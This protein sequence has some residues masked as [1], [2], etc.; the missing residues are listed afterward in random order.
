M[1]NV[2]TA[3]KPIL[4]RAL[5]TVSREMIGFIPAVSRDS[6]AESAAVGQVVTYHKVPAIALETITPGAEPADSGDAT[7]TAGTMTI[8][9]QKVAPIR[10]EG[11][12]ELT[13]INGDDP[14]LDTVVEDQF[15]QAFRAVTN[16]VE[17][18]LGGLYVGA[19][20]AYGTAGTTP[21][22]TIDELDDASE[23]LRILEDNGA[24]M[25]DNHLVLG[26]AATAKLRGYQGVMFKR[27]EGQERG[28][29]SLGELFGMDI[30]QSGQVKTHTIGTENGAYLLNDAS[31]AIGDTSIALDTGAGTI[32]AGDFLLNQETGA[33]P[34]YYGVTT[35]LSGGAAVIAEPG[36]Q[37]A[38]TDDDSVENTSANFVANMAFNRRAIQ[39]VA[40]APQMPQ[41]GDKASDVFSVTDPVSGLTFQVARYAQYRRVKYE[42]GLAWGAEL[43]KP[44]HCAVLFG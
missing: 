31:S 9:N 14:Q 2:I 18:D 33:D 32:V 41:G 30:H 43:V 17:A 5:D 19:S 40:R 10:W 38:W 16:A 22:A 15:A 21:F 27:N 4:Y 8:D 42:I 37:V 44:E 23:V 7:I 12:E 29:D 20:R 28:S 26:S 36:L 35:A 1:S 24:P 34:R 25:G 13:L 6:R 39:L 11:E 3:I